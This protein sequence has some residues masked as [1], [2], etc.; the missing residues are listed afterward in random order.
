MITSITFDDIS[1]AYLSIPKMEWLVN[2]LNEL[3]I[4]CTFFVVPCQNYN[5]R[6]RREFA[7]FLRSATAFGHELS[8]HGYKHAKNEFGYFYPV[9]LPVVPI[10][11]LSKQKKRIG[12]AKEALIQLAGVEPLGFRSPFYLYNSATL[13]ALSSLNFKYD[14][15]K[16]LFKPTHG[17]RW[18]IR[19]SR[20]PKPHKVR[21]II[22]IPV[23]G[24]YTYNLKDEN[25]LSSI[26]RALRDFN[27][28]RSCNGVFVM[29]IHATRSHA[30]LLQR[31]LQIFV[32]KIREKTDFVKLVDVNL[33]ANC[34]DY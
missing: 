34:D 33:G 26:G 8:L 28:I 18:R 3:E 7:A 9:P 17:T 14:S 15:S 24:D 30:K 32:N 23:S 11:S 19:W 29:N 22:E 20:H 12:L 1:P 2:F 5:P 6:L 21:G 16:T 31:F 13:D 10:P 4:N 25:L 27:W